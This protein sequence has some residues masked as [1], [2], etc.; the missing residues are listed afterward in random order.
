M[1][2][3][4]LLP[5]LGKRISKIDRLLNSLSNQVIQDFEVI[6]VTQINHEEVAKLVSK[7]N[8]LNIKQVKI[9]KKGLSI[10]RN[11]GLDICTGEWILISDD[12][13]W[14][15]FDALCMLKDAIKEKNPDILLTQIF[16]PISNQ[17]YKNYLQEGRV[18]NHKFDLMSKSSIEIT[19]KREIITHKFDERFGLG[20]ELVCGEEVD[21]LLNH[22]A[23]NRIVYHPKVSV[24]HQKKSTKD[25]E[26]QI[27]A[28]GAIYSKHYNV[29]VGLLVITRD[30][31]KKKENNWRPFWI[32][33]KYYSKLR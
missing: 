6:I 16:D 26:K 8:N 12:D 33:F 9:E 21:F 17:L 18:I 2:F 15:P 4:I 23:G 24:Y 14:Y 20:A 32:G 31:I 13:C 30:L 19:I 7:W 25:S 5:T 10:A 29:L 28:K 27:I 22:F 1:M 3:S 11:V